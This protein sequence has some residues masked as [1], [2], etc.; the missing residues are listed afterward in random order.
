M[1]IFLW[2]KRSRSR[3]KRL[4]PEKKH[5]TKQAGRGKCLEEA[6][7]C[8]DKEKRSVSVMWAE[9]L[10]IRGQEKISIL[11][12]NGELLI[13]ENQKKSGREEVEANS[14]KEFRD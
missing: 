3:E 11:L 10:N 12:I 8:W 2:V 9:S 6:S 1:C 14:L 13:K 5:I 4:I 7:T